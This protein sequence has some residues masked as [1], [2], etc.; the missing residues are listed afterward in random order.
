[1]KNQWKADSYKRTNKCFV[2]AP[3]NDGSSS[4]IYEET[5]DQTE[6][7]SK[8]AHL[9]AAAPEMLEALESVLNNNK[10]MNALDPQ[11]RRLVMDSVHKAKGGA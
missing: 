5:T 10:V 11:T 4:I 7:V 9:I 2:S 6:Q 8:R 3:N 1:M